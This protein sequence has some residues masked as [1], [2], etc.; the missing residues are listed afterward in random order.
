MTKQSL[1]I[2]VTLLLIGVGNLYGETNNEPSNIKK[3]L[4]DEEYQIA[5]MAFALATS[6][7]SVHAIALRLSRREAS[8]LRTEENLSWKD[9][10]KLNKIHTK[11]YWKHAAYLVIGTFDKLNDI[12]IK[13]KTPEG[14][15][16]KKTHK[17]QPPTGLFCTVHDVIKTSTKKLNAIFKDTQAFWGFITLCITYKILENQEYEKLINNTK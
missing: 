5:R 4:M 1:N 10:F 6:L 2:I 12:I 3:Y 13:T 16:I 9:L 15:H 14:W 11:D 7:I 17:Y 8:R